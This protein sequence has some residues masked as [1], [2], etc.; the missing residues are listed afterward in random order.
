MSTKTYT[1]TNHN[2]DGSDFSVRVPCPDVL[3]TPGQEITFKMACRTLAGNHY[4]SGDNLILIGRTATA[5]HDVSSSLGNWLVRCKYF[6][7]VWS[8]IEWG[9]AKGWLE[10]TDKHLDTLARHMS[11]R[12]EGQ[13]EICEN[14]QLDLRISRPRLGGLWALT[15]MANDRVFDRDMYRHDLAER[16]G[17]TLETVA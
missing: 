8:N 13:F 14:P 6:T 1:L 2:E 7:S 16:Y 12:Y 9:L 17:L 5:P 4:Q 11:V 10:A 15:D 3:P